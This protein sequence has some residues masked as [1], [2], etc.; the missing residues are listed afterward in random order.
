MNIASSADAWAEAGSRSF[1]PL[2]VDRIAADFEGRLDTRRCGDAGLTAVS[3][4]PCR[5]ARRQSHIDESTS[6]YLLFS[7]Q[8][9][10]VNAVTQQRRSAYVAP[11]EGV[12]YATGSPYQLDFP[13][14]NGALILQVPIAAIGLTRH[15]AERVVARTIPRDLPSMRVLSNYM[16]VLFKESERDDAEDDG[17]A[18]AFGRV[19][20][21][22][23]GAVLRQVLGSSK[24]D[25]RAEALVEALKASIRRHLFDPAISV[26]TL[27]SMHHLSA[28]SV[29]A[30]FAS[31]GE[32][33]TG[34]I[35]KQRM[36]HAADW[37]AKTDSSISEIAYGV[38]YSD[39]T[40]F[41][42][43]FVKHHGMTP[44]AYRQ[45]ALMHKSSEDGAQ[46][47]W[48]SLPSSS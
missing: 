45:A 46:E 1:V 23:L 9:R 7:L 44:R 26:S 47:G 32:S 34:F 24:S 28:R 17:E 43:A 38:G 5:V 18:D 25:A 39:P 6:D 10:G 36:V 20:A 30:A 22:L 27:A 33:P 37:V 12:V 21:D 41:T 35:R 40:L 14:P 3:S 19:A 2:G 11:G 42:R 29:Y 13:T 16:R 4:G 8:A 48:V 31:G 15:A